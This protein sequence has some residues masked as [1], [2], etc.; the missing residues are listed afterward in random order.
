MPSHTKVRSYQIAHRYRYKFHTPLRSKRAHTNSPIA[1]FAAAPSVH[2]SPSRKMRT[3]IPRERTNAVFAF[4]LKLNAV[5]RGSNNLYGAAAN[6]EEVINVF[7]IRYGCSAR[8]ASRRGIIERWEF[9]SSNVSADRTAPRSHCPRRDTCRMKIT[10]EQA[11]VFITKRAAVANSCIR[12]ENTR[13]VYY[14]RAF[15]F[16]ECAICSVS[17]WA[18]PVHSMDEPLRSTFSGGTK[19]L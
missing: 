7:R 9:D 16:R 6:H 8:R 10:R 12:G 11:R 19:E 13:P 15:A 3:I 18:I 5:H 17:L 1:I 4:D 2:C 14:E